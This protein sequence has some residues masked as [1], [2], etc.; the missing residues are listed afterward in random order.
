MSHTAKSGCS[1]YQKSHKNEEKDIICGHA[2]DSS[3]QYRG[4][5]LHR[6]G[7]E[8]DLKTLVLSGKRGPSGRVKEK[9]KTKS[10]LK[11]KKERN[12]SDDYT[13]KRGEPLTPH[14]RCDQLS[15]V[16][17]FSSQ[18]NRREIL[19]RF[20]VNTAVVRKRCVG[21]RG[22]YGYSSFYDS[23]N[24]Q[25]FLGRKIEIGGY[26]GSHCKEINSESTG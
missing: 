7:Q 11:R 24:S 13:Q 8:Q 26:F 12:D 10:I 18:R 22:K 6:A 16:T 19:R 2:D 14:V 21:A 17:T 5:A 3:V 23:P 4:R 20:R 25:L 9:R 15:R 1:L